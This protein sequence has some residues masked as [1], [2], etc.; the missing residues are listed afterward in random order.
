MLVVVYE[1]ILLCTTIMYLTTSASSDILNI[2]P[3]KEST[4]NS[5]LVI[6]QTSVDRSVE[7]HGFDLHVILTHLFVLG[8]DSSM[9]R[10]NYDGK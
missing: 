7:G 8:S 5:D 3:I 4:C 10:T 9:F 2:P 6:F 1:P